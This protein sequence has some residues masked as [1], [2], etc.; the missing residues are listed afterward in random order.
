VLDGLLGHPLPADWDDVTAVRRGTGR[1]SL[2]A[3]DRGVLGDDADAFPL[4]G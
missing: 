3:D 2:T 1:E 4:F